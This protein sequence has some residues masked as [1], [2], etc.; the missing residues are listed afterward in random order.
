MEMF[1]F[2]EDFVSD[3]EVRCR[4]SS[5]ISGTL[6]AFLGFGYLGLEFLVQCV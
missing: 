6:I 3:L 4:S 1:G 5:G 2:D